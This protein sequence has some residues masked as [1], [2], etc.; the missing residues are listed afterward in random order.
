MLAL[1]VDD[2]EMVCDAVARMVQSEAI[3]AYTA[4]TVEQA[5]S[6]CKAYDI[7]IAIIDA[8]IPP[9]SGTELIKI[10]RKKFPLLKIIGVTSFVEEA[11]MIEFLQ[12]GVVGFLPK[13]TLR[14]TQMQA[15][16]EQVLK[17][18]TYFSNEVIALREKLMTSIKLPST[19]LSK[20]ELEIC[21]LTSK[22][23]QSKE[24]AV[25]LGIAK[26][27]VDFYKKQLLEKTNTK[28]GTELVNFLFRNGL[29]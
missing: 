6:I 13:D 16:L 5:L 20:R 10:L 21:Q 19:H 3:Q 14:Q 1:V 26:S 4:Y 22:G 9:D 15:C 17:G 29:L 24:V 25:K 2:H 18:N 27:T 11:T 23:W 7:S 28:N 12:A 8:R